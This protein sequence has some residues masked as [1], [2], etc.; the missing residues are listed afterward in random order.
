[1]LQSYLETWLKKE[2]VSSNRRRVIQ[3]LYWA[4]LGK[5]VTIF[6]EL[7]V[8]VMIARTLGPERFGLMN[9]VISLVMLFS[10]FAHFGLDGIE[11]RE[12]SRADAPK[13]KILGTA[14]MLRGLCALFTVIAVFFT[15]LRFESD[16]ETFQLVMLYALSLL[17]S[18]FVTLRNYFTSIIRHEYVVKSEML[19]TV[20]GAGIKLLVLRFSPTLLFLVAAFT[21]DFFLVG[22]G[23]FFA[24]K[25]KA[26]SGI[27]RLSL[28]QTLA[29]ALL[30]G[31][32]PLLLSAAA[33]VFYQRIN[34]IML[35]HLLDDSAVGQFA[36]AAKLTQFT[37]FIPIIL[38]QSITPLLVKAHSDDPAVYTRKRQEFMDW[39]VW[40]GLLLSAM[41]SLA[42]A[43][44]ISILYGTAYLPAIP[45]LQIMAWKIVFVAL[46]N[47][48]G[49]IMIIENIH[50][51]AVYRNVLG[52][53]ISIVGNWL[54]IP[55]FGAVGSAAVT[56]VTF[57]VA[58]FLAHVITLIYRPI[59]FIQ[60]KSFSKGFIR[61]YLNYLKF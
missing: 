2:G 19:R 33:I 45:V 48:S 38:A 1:M 42:A 26:E 55:V 44:V 10:V 24:Y 21:L 35:R 27:G 17:A 7:L 37:L 32:F 16:P 23:Y 12:L 22:F 13:G 9:Y 52:V 8:G 46:T 14:M 41:T 36:V 28:D 4:V 57:L 39:M 30:R 47:A 61:I 53:V 15:L 31:A 5:C 60:L 59:F 50:Q 49:Q 6:S 58:G 25:R 56:V 34:A 18:P 40:T 3:N 29:A 54:M 20:L 11:I 51:Y 43:P